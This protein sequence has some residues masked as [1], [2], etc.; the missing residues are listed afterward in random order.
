MLTDV[1]IMIGS[2]QA[3]NRRPLRVYY[4]ISMKYCLDEDQKTHG[5]TTFSHL[6]D[7]L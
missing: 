2:S 3:E 7:K 5:E 6:L 4:M 1:R